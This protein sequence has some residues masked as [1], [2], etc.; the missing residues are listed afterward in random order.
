MIDIYDLNE[1]N[2]HIRRLEETAR[3]MKYKR[4]HPKETAAAQKKWYEKKG[5]EY[6]RNYRLKNN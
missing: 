1:I 6:H 5:V 3:I 4:E 2:E